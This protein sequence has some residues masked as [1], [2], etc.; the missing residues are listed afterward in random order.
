[1]ANKENSPDILAQKTF[2]LTVVGAL[3]YIAVVFTFVIGG[4]HREAAQHVDAPKS[5]TFQGQTGQGQ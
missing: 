3:L 4:N 1:M 5:I 2:F